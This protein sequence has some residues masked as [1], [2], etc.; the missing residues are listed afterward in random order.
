MFESYQ[1]GM[2]PTHQQVQELGYEQ[3]FFF[4]MRPK[5]LIASI[6]INMHSLG[7]A[8]LPVMVANEGLGWD[9]RT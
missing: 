2:T 4:A 8:P 3:L 1:Q 5:R 6:N 9:S 7:V